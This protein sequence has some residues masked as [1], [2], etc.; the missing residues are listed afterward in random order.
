MIRI[1]PKP[2]LLSQQV[3]QVS[4]SS[5]MIAIPRAV[6]PAGRPRDTSLP[7]TLLVAVLITLIVETVSSIIGPPAVSV[8]GLIMIV[9]VG[10]LAYLL[11]SRSCEYHRRSGPPRMRGFRRVRRPHSMGVG[12]LVFRQWTSHC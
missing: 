8:G 3:M 5:S 1:V 2:A 6:V 9:R 4:P 11:R 7:T 12:P 10:A